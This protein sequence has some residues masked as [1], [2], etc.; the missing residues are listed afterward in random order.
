MIHDDFYMCEGVKSSTRLRAK[1]PPRQIKLSHKSVMIEEKQVEGLG[2]GPGR[3]SFDS[4]PLEVLCTAAGFPPPSFSWKF[5]NIHLQSGAILQFPGGMNRN[6]SG[7]YSCEA[8]NKL[9][10]KSKYIDINVL[11]RLERYVL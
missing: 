10:V 6:Q 8:R 4:S 1:Y 5:K 11:Y 3:D 7:R 2:K 9:G